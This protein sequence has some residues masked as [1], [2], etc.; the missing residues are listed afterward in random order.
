MQPRKTVWGGIPQVRAG[1]DAGG[2]RMPMTVRTA[3]AHVKDLEIRADFGK[4]GSKYQSFI[5]SIS[6]RP[7]Y[8][9][10]YDLWP[11]GG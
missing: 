9:N 1:V 4:F 10:Y 7:N 2:S 3:H 6:V 11:L 8:G 5:R